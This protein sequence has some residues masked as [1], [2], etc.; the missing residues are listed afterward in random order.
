MSVECEERQEANRSNS[1]ARDTDKRH[2]FTP[3]A[4]SP[5]PPKYY[6]QLLTSLN[7]VLVLPTAQGAEPTATSLP[8]HPEIVLL[9][10][11][12][13]ASPELEDR[14][15]IDLVSLCLKL[16]LLVVVLDTEA[17]YNRKPVGSE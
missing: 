16:L 3:E 14:F 17:S 5:A 10:A 2:T 9:D 15:A 6:F 11:G 12:G 1:Q 13:T 8:R 7:R 4:C